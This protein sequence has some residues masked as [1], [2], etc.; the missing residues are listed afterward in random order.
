MAKTRQKQNGTSSTFIIILLRIRYIT[1]TTTIKQ[2]TI[3]TIIMKYQSIPLLSLF[4]TFLHHLPLTM[5]SSELSSPFIGSWTL[6]QVLE[7]STTAFALPEG[8]EFVMNLQASPNTDEDGNEMLGLSL[9]IGNSLH[10]SM[11]LWNEE[12]DDDDDDD[13]TQHQVAIRM[14]FVMSTKMLSPEPLNSLEILLSKVL[15]NLDTMK[16]VSN[17]EDNND[18]TKISLIMDSSLGF[19]RLVFTTATLQRS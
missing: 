1:N 4:L 7:D 6:L 9:Q 10:S 12:E 8:K 5:A 11:S 3:I 2:T 17:E 16:V 18:S 13:E 15:P 19:G 14:G